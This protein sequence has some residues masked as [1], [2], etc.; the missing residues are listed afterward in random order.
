LLAEVDEPEPVRTRPVKRRA[1]TAKTTAP[2]A[3]AQR[4]RRK[5]MQPQRGGKY[6]PLDRL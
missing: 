4:S 6:I 2:K 3:G 1:T 5:D